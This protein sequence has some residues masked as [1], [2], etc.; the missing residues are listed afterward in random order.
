M[1]ILTTKSIEVIPCMKSPGAICNQTIHYIAIPIQGLV[2]ILK[3]CVTDNS[4]KIRQQGCLPSHEKVPKMVEMTQTIMGDK[5]PP[6][7]IGHTD[8][9]KGSHREN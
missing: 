4:W 1:T 5:R 7:T 6:L 3:L 2:D 8:R 9:G